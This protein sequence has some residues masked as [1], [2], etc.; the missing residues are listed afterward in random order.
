MTPQIVNTERNGRTIEDNLVFSGQPKSDG[1]VRTLGGGIFDP[2][3]LVHDDHDSSTRHKTAH[4]I[5]QL[6]RY[7]ES[8]NGSDQHSHDFPGILC[9]VELLE[10]WSFGRVAT[11]IVFDCGEFVEF[12]APSCLEC[13]RAN[14]QHSIDQPGL[15]PCTSQVNCRVRLAGAHFRKP[16]ACL[17]SPR[18]IQ[19]L[20]LMCQRCVGYF[21]S[22][23]IIHVIGKRYDLRFG[24]Q[25]LMILDRCQCF[26]AELKI[27]QVPHSHQ[28]FHIGLDQSHC[29]T[30]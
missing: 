14:D 10:P 29:P 21:R 2:R 13:G 28:V 25:L 4:R 7:P 24:R 16:G 9:C 23:E 1:A 11:Q 27:V 18:P 30:L 22:R 19:H 15:V 6:L 8:F 3:R 12:F 5:V 20:F 26:L 17:Q